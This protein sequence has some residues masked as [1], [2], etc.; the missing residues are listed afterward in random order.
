MNR[1]NLTPPNA[2]PGASG[3]L[4]FPALLGLMALGVL[5]AVGAGARDHRRCFLLWTA[6]L[7]LAIGGSFQEGEEGVEGR[8]RLSAG[9]VGAAHG[10]D[11]RR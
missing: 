7:T 9:R 10:R 3:R 11:R 5:A 1:G 2:A 6:R 4:R 8:R